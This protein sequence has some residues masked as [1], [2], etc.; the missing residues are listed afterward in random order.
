MSPFRAKL[1]ITLYRKG[2]EGCA[3]DAMADQ[4]LARSAITDPIAEAF[5]RRFAPVVAFAPLAKPFASV[6][7]K[8]CF[9]Y[10]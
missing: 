4:S 1:N 9:F 7:V 10:G 6:A 3:K 8:R 2:R 5:I